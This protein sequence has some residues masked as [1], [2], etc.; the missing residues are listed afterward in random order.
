MTWHSHRSLDYLQT[1]PSFLL[2]PVSFSDCWDDYFWLTL[3]SSVS[4]SSTTDSVLSVMYVVLSAALS[5]LMVYR[6]PSQMNQD[7]DSIWSNCEM[8]AQSSSWLSLTLKV[9]IWTHSHV[10]QDRMH[11]KLRS[12]TWRMLCWCRNWWLL[13]LLTWF[14]THYSDSLLTVSYVLAWHRV[15][16]QF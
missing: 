5:A 8:T 6:G 14:F 7:S 3:Y 11:L 16:D 12:L 9:F 4:S 1:C 2:S 13:R 10:N 15:W